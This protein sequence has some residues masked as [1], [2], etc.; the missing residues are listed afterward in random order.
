MNLIDFVEVSPLYLIKR[1]YVAFVVLLVNVTAYRAPFSQ[2][3]V[4]CGA[5]IIFE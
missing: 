1:T 4:I 5:S 2:K 3:G